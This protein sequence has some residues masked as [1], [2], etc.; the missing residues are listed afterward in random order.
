MQIKGTYDVVLVPLVLPTAYLVQTLPPSIRSIQ[1]SPFIPFT[2]QQIAAL[3]IDATDFDPDT[4]HPVMLELGYQHSTGPPPFG[5]NFQEAKLEI[6]GMRHPHAP[7]ASRQGYVF[8]QHI[9]FDSFVLNL[10]SNWLAGL[11]SARTTFSPKQSPASYPASHQGTLHYNVENFVEAT[12]ERTTDD[13]QETAAAAEL[14]RWAG[15]PWYGARTPR[16]TLT[17]FNFDLSTQAF[18]PVG[19]EGVVR[20]RPE[21]FLDASASSQGVEGLSGAEWIEMD[22]VR[23]WRFKASFASEDSKV[24]D[25]A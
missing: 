5:L 24:T 8:K 19:Y 13:T 21:A 17:Q 14:I 16:A 15:R 1:P 23:A 3:G 2:S 6:L 20:M 12:F 18:E 10:S 22:K 11:R 4:H 25:R 7:S 9:L